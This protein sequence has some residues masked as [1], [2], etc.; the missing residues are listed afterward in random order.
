[1]SPIGVLYISWVAAAP[2]H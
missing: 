2:F 1:M